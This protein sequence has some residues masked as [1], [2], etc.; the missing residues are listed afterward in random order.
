[1]E[2][3]CTKSGSTLGAGMLQYHNT[4]TST[5]ATNRLRNMSQEYHHLYNCHQQVEEHVSR[6][7]EVVSVDP[8]AM[9][10][11]DC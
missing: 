2:Q 8:I 4:T 11:A 7:S 5:T 3:D 6:L 9:V 10:T 1:M